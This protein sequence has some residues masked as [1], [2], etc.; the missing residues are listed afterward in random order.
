MELF[1]GDGGI[2]TIICGPVLST[3]QLVSLNA[4]QLAKQA[5][6]PLA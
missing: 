6:V 1:A 3:K 4:E 2:T 5:S